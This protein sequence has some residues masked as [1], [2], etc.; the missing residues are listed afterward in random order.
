MWSKYWVF[1]G[2]LK[3][4]KYNETTGTYSKR[5]SKTLDPFI[6]LN[7]E[8]LAKCISYIT[9]M[10]NQEELEDKDVEELIERGNF[11]KL[12]PILINKHLKA[13]NTQSGF[14]GVWIKY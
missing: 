2:M 1:Q 3:I 13:R 6:E 5:T 7:P 8:V 9:K 10:V 12:Y 14:D 11:Q 4:G